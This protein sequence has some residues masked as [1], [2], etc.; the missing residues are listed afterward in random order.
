MKA[1][2]C[3]LPLLR[4]RVG[5]LP[6]LLG[7]G[8]WYTPLS[9][10]FRPCK[11]HVC[12]GRPFYLALLWLGSIHQL[13]LVHTTPTVFQTLETTRLS[14]AASFPGLALA[15]VRTS[16]APCFTR[17]ARRRYS[18]APHFMG[19]CLSKLC[20]RPLL[21]NLK[22]FQQKLRGQGLGGRGDHILQLSPFGVLHRS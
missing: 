17:G 16:N 18:P 4:H 10:Y 1:Q 21:E 5:C 11:R 20:S 22:A 13:V 7:G 8:C 3:R 12:P 19:P 2:P 6:S 15:G 9:P 14:W